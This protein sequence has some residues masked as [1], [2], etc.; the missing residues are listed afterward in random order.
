MLHHL[1]FYGCLYDPTNPSNAAA[2]G[3]NGAVD[4]ESQLGNPNGGCTELFYTWALG[5]N[6]LI[7]PNGVGFSVGKDQDKLWTHYLIEFHYHN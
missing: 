2:K 3:L 4:G 7:M 5:A 6:P 1:L